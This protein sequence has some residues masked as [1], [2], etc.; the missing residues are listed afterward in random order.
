MSLPQA[1]QTSISGLR[2]TQAGLA[3]VASNVANAQTPGYV[4]KTLIQQT[5]EAGGASSGVRVAGIN[6]ELDLFIQRQ[7][8]VESSGG[9]YAD[10]RAQFYQRIQQIYG[11]PGS[12]SSLE[13]V[14]NNFTNAV[15]ALTTSPDMTT[16]RGA[17]ITSAQVLA[18]QLNGMTDD[19]Q[20][21]RG[22]AENGIADAVTVANEA[23]RQIASINGQLSSMGSNDAS[24]A[25]LMDQRDMFIDQLADLMDI[26]VVMSEPNQANVFTNSGI[27]LV[28]MSASQLSFNPQGTMGPQ[29]QWST[30]PSQRSV[31]SLMLVSPSGGSMDLIANNSIRAGKIAAFIDMRDNVLVEAQNQLDGLA[32]AMASAL[33]DKTVSGAGVISGAQ[34]GF[35]MDLGGLLA[36][37]T[38][39]LTY[40]DMTTGQQRQVTLVRV[41]DPSVLPLKNDFTANP[42]DEVIGFDP[43]GGL[44]SLV[45]QL[46]SRFNGK[47]QFSNTGG[48]VL[49]V[50]DDGAANNT[51]ITGFS[52]RQTVTSLNGG[53]AELPLFTDASD[54]YTGAMTGSGRQ[55]LGFAGRISVNAS[56]VADPSKLVA[57]GPG[58]AAGNSTRPE[59]IYQSLIGAGH[60]FSPE[61][62][63]GTAASPFSGSLSG[64][65][66]QV[67]SHQGAAAEAASSLAEGQAVVVN[68]LEQ[69]VADQAGVNV[70]QEMANL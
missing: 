5:T 51:T 57:Y 40:T 4:R 45:S 70:D 60:D 18:Q 25:S 9:S 50:L 39:T 58:V 47:L 23:M 8:R 15:Q 52:A 30:D 63:I 56:L 7:L 35:D 13:S 26:K 34:S 68:A 20:A 48:N 16:A 41:D 38:A 3:L 67:L 42:N 6:R 46:N 62:G 10:L 29:A 61:T 55:S 12:S 33:S 49:R 2:T 66:R 11:A 44:A 22:D 28:G 19:I 54:P 17:V 37:N 64:Y 59:F 27:Q 53:G 36:G 24:A 14:F 43:S 32:A 1:L 21:L 65:L 31:G 69:K